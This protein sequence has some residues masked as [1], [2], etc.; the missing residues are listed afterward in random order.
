VLERM[1]AE[2]RRTKDEERGTKKDVR[3]AG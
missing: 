1:K 3:H 2:G